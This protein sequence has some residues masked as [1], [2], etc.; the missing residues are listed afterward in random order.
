MFNARRFTVKNFARLTDIAP[1]S[2][3]NCLMSEA[4]ANNGQLATQAGE[5]FRHTTGFARH[6]GARR[7]HQYRIAHRRQ[8][9]N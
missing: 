6:T 8:A 2:F 9:F 5:E 1:V 4:N 3:D 7:K